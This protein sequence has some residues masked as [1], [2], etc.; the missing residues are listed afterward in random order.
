MK[1]AN[2]TAGKLVSRHLRVTVIPTMEVKVFTTFEEAQIFAN[3]VR[4]TFEP[5]AAISFE[6]VE[7]SEHEVSL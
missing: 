3:K 1:R 6:C 4:A 5:A 7:V 2:Y